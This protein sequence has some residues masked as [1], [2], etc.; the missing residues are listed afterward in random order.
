MS[1]KTASDHDTLLVVTI[2][3]FTLILGLL[4]TFVLAH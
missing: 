1:N 3:L 4:A 2:S